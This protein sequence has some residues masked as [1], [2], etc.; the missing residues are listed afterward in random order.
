[1]FFLSVVAIVFVLFAVSFR[2]LVGMCRAGHPIY[3]DGISDSFLQD[4]NYFGSDAYIS[5]APIRRGGV[6]SSPWLLVVRH[7]LLLG[8]DVRQ[9]HSPMG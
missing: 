7:R 5:Y 9:R 6:L 4:A 3:T 8:S 1:M 2:V